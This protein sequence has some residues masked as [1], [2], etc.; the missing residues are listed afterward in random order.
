MPQ[1]RVAVLLRKLGCELLVQVLLR[2]VDTEKELQVCALR[3]A[4]QIAA[5]GA[6]E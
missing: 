3:R 5:V 4:Y 2:S 1:C 6:Y